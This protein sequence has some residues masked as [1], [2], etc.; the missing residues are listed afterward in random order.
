[1]ILKLTVLMAFA[2][3][4]DLLLKRAPAALR[5]LVW[6][7][8]LVSA[9]VLP[10]GG[11]YAP[12]IAGPAFVIRTSAAADA[13]LAPSNFHWLPAIYVAVM[14]I[15]LVRLALDILAANRLVREAHATSL[16][17]VLVSDRAVTPFAW[18]SIVVP[19]GLENCA[20]VLAHERA[21]LERGDVFTSLI[22]RV[23]CAVYWFHPLV[24]W[25]ASRMR[26]EADRAC[27][28][29]VLRCGFD[30]AGY[31]ANLV[32]IARNFHGPALAPGAVQPSQLEVRVR[33]ILAVGVDR[34]K[35]GASAFAV[36][37]LTALLVVGPLSALSSE[38]TA[39]PVYSIHDGVSAPAV[40]SKVNPQYS[41]H[42][43]AAKIQGPCLLTIV[44]G[45]DGLAHDIKVQRSLDPSLDAAAI[46]AIRKWKFKPGTKAGAAVN[47]R[48]TIEVN[49]RLL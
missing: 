33:H 12:R 4:A 19:A 23:A 30:D 32:E 35:L 39:A 42:A 9:L 3:L 46:A 2:C 31:A 7:L 48:A 24:W 8:T 21:H 49:F 16:P 20:A 6:S 28:D 44:V 25:A 18:G 22:A 47:V 5:H 29:A 40:L 13:M 36:A 38:Q 27:D 17:G 15:M 43:R 10:V 26:L 11:L 37:M 34:R 41:R 45:T 14:A 1:V